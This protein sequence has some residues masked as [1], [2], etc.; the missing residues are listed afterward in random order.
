MAQFVPGPLQFCLQ[1]LNAN[2]GLQQV[3]VKIVIL[4]LQLP[5]N[6]RMMGHG[7][8]SQNIFILESIYKRSLLDPDQYLYS[9]Y[10]FKAQSSLGKSFSSNNL[11]NYT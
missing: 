11:K 5:E 9:K 4:L 7:V 6:R 2:H 3:L 10:T 1:A 8:I